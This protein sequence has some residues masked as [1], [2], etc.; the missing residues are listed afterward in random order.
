TAALSR[1]GPKHSPQPVV[2]SSHTISTMQLARVSARLK[3]HENG[4]SIVASSTWV[5][6][7]T[8]FINRSR[9]LVLRNDLSYRA[10]TLAASGRVDVP[11]H[12]TAW[13][14]NWR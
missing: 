12:Y 9:G 13:G 1:A 8:I 7:S 4:G 3:D 2:P 14:Q 5:L 11:P 6:T 10:P